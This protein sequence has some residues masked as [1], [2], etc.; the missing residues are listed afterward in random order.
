MYKDPLDEATKK[1]S[2]EVREYIHYAVKEGYM[3][4][5]TAYNMTDKEMNEY[6]D[7]GMAFDPMDFIEDLERDAD[8]DPITGQFYK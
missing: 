6:Y 4:D 5:D 8:I 3:D 7:R 1:V 2:K